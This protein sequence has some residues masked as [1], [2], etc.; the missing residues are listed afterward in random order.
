MAVLKQSACEI[1]SMACCTDTG[2]LCEQC[3]TAAA[4]CVVQALYS[5]GTPVPHDFVIKRYP[6]QYIQ[7]IE[8]L[9]YSHAAH[10][11][12]DHVQHNSCVL[13]AGVMHITSTLEWPKA[14]Q[15]FLKKHCG[16]YNL[17]FNPGA[18]IVKPITPLN[19]FSRIS[20]LDVLRTSYP[21]GI[22]QDTIVSEYENAYEDLFVLL[23]ERT[24]YRLGGQIWRI[25]AA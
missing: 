23:Q 11:T 24:C 5:L 13:L 2:T 18:A 9:R 16:K 12:H 15:R 10:I 17:Y 3:T 1:R 21:Q 14:A 6:V 19:M 8:H 20:M 7:I 25:R 22:H 4:E